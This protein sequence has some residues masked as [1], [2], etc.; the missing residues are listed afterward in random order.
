MTDSID[1]ALHMLGQAEL[2]RGAANFENAVMERIDAA[3][4]AREAWPTLG[5]EAAGEFSA[6]NLPKTPARRNVRF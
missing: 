1:W 5:T 2:P 3:M 4:R 6:K